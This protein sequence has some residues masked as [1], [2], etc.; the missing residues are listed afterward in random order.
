[1]F[2]NLTTKRFSVIDYAA[3]NEFIDV[4]YVISDL[5]C[6][7]SQSILD[8]V[9]DQI[10]WCKR[11]RSINEVPYEC[12]P[13]RVVQFRDFENIDWEPVMTGAHLASSYLIRKGP[14]SKL[15]MIFDNNAVF[16]AFSRLISK[17]SNE[18]SAQTL[19]QQAS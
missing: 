17:S 6:S 8:Q 10:S 11:V 19:L 14:K 16:G 2:L 15:I 7:Y 12:S 1:M 4:I 13:L 3:S 5:N 9:I 18:P